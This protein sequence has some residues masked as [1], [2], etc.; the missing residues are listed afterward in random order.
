MIFSGE[1]FV[2]EF[3]YF[4]DGEIFV[5]EFDG[6]KILFANIEKISYNDKEKLQQLFS[7]NK[8][9]FA[10][11]NG[12]DFSGVEA[13]VTASGGENDSANYSTSMM[14]NF[15]YNFDKNYAWGLD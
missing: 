7:E 8:F 15:T 1:G 12:Y 2:D 9:D 6:L 13:K 14:G 10:F 11:V 4:S 5:I 3:R